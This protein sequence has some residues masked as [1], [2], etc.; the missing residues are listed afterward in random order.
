MNTTTSHVH[1]RS[2]NFYKEFSYR[3]KVN[4]FDALTTSELVSRH[5]EQQA[6]QCVKLPE[7]LGNL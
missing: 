2:V 6:Q 3:L 5:T 4:E 7:T 1:F